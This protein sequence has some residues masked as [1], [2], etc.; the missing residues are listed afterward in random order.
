M[1]LQSSKLKVNKD[2][3]E[4]IDTSLSKSHTTQHDALKL[5]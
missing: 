2:I 5:N 3:D 1:I 4:N